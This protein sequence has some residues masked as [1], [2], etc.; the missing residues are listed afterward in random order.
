MHDMD[1]ISQLKIR[2][3][4][5]QLGNSAIGNYPY[6]SLVGGN[7]YYPIGGVSTQGQSIVTKGNPELRWETSTQT[8]VGLDLG[9]LKGALQVTLDY[10]IKNTSDVLL[11][12]PQPSSAGNGGNPA[13]NAGKIRNHGLEAGAGLPQ[14]RWPGLDLWRERQP[15]HAA[16]R[17]DFAGQR[18]P[19]RGR[20]RRQQLLRHPHLV[21][22]PMGSFYLLQQEGIF[23]NAQE[24]FT[25]AYQ[26]P[27]IQPGDMS[28]SRISAA[29]TGCP[30][31]S[32]TA[33]TAA[34]W[35]AP[36]RSSPTA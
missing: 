9:L 7:F 4:V 24:V 23:Q 29:R 20:A 25:H 5:G 21:G 2:A 12:L 10:F 34:S 31:A 6:A 35:A 11:F 3:S 14:Q 13:V 19:H 18:R 27:G 30:M 17:G 33:A 1:A 8:N 36:F 22:Q 16:Q 26:G 28:S 32:S 15:G